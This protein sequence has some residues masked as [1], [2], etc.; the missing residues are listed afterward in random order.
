[1]EKDLLDIS[2]VELLD[3]F[4]AGKHKPGSGSAAAFQAMISSKLLI[5]VIGI[6]NRPNQQKKYSSYLP[7]LLKYLEDLETRIFPQLSELFIN[8]AIEF[9]RAIEL[10]T[11]RN[12]EADPIYKNQLRRE[13]LEQMK[14]AIAIPL[15]ISN[16]SIELCEIANYVFDNA[17]K[18]A[19]GDSHVAFSGAVAALAGSLSII[20]LNLLQFGSDDF[21]Y[22]EEIRSKLHELDIDYTNYNSLATSKISIL[23]KEFDTKAPF[24]LELND[25]LDKLKINKRPSDLDIEKGISDFQNL[26]WKHKDIIWKNP[27]QEPREIL[28]P[29]LIFKDVLCYDYVT[30]EEFGVPDDEGNVIEIQG[31]INQPNRLV[32]ISNK[33]P[34]A[35]QRFTGAHELAH[36]LFHDQKLQ[37]RDLPLENSNIHQ[38]RPFE[39]KVA[40]KGATYFLMPKKDIIKQFIL[41]FGISSFSINEETSFNL[42][43]GSIS[44][45]KRECKNIREFSRKLS[46]V[47]SYNGHRFESLSQRFNVSVEAMAIRLEQLDLLRY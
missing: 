27:P 46:S 29:K 35:T 38:I 37:H 16:L 28:D 39:E 17:F 33:F 19:R 22:C 18:S 11:L 13:A 7:T 4:G 40:D 26:V 2:T 42:I 23:Q 44:D 43:R 32:V 12:Q 8:D 24:Y 6:T 36:A 20:R 30:R 3:K 31:L 47:E 45:L 14:V 25:L 34:E 9:D 10:R 5:T 41:R 15:D 21:R 1:M